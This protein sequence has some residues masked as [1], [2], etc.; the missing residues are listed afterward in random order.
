MNY[1]LTILL[2]A[3][4]AL[5][6]ACQGRSGEQPGDAADPSDADANSAVSAPEEPVSII[7]PEIEPPELPETPLEAFEV[8]LGFPQGGDELDA[9]ATA[10]LEALL[11]AEQVA[12]GGSITLRAHSDAGGSDAAN[13]RASQARG[14]KVRDWLVQKGIAESRVSVIAFGEQNPAQPNANPDGSPN[15]E[16]RAANRRVDITVATTATTAPVTGSDS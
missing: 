5:L 6:G 11:T 16:G 9:S 14:D 3:L 1:R 15:E 2:L 10:A 4:L 7:R 8:T 12:R 13:L